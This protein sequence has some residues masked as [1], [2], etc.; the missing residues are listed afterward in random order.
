MLVALD[1]GGYQPFIKTLI[2]HNFT[3]VG[4][5]IVIIGLLTLAGIWSTK[6]GI[7]GGLLAFLMSIVTLSYHTKSLCAQFRR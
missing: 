6:L 3:R 5:V 4:T 1:I 2:G 7:I